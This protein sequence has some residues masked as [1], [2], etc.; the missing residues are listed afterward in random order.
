MMSW[1]DSK[2]AD[3]TLLLLPCEVA[4]HIFLGQ[5]FCI[6]ADRPHSLSLCRGGLQVGC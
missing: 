5:H 3:V 6:D 4:M 1:E 2:V